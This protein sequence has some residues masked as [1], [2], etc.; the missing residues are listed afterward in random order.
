MFRSV[1]YWMKRPGFYATRFRNRLLMRLKR[2]EFQEPPVIRGQL[3]IYGQGK[4][5]MG[6]GVTINSSRASNPIGGDTRTQFAVDPGAV[7]KIGDHT[8]ISNATIVVRESVTIGKH[9][10]I[11][12]SVKIYDTDF[13][14]LD[15]KQ[16]SDASRDQGRNR[17]VVLGDYSFIG[18]HSIILKGVSIGEAS[19]IG[20]GSVVT[21][22]VPAYEIWG[23]NP[24]K[25][26]KKVQR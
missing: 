17:P 1:Y 5:I 20:A 13:H 24:A 23:G 14:S 16:R 22:D 12:G 4:I 10:K 7:L 15:P 8:G 9:V 25:F 6:N 18:G 26:I 21:R 2:V 19:I 3:H 11:G